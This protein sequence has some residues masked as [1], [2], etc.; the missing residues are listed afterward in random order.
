MFNRLSYCS[1]CGQ[2][3]CHFSFCALSNELVNS[4]LFPPRPSHI[5]PFKLLFSEARGISDGKGQPGSLWGSSSPLAGSCSPASW[6]ACFVLLLLSDRMWSFI[7]QPD[8]SIFITRHRFSAS[9]KAQVPTK[10][11]FGM[12]PKRWSNPS[13]TGRSETLHLFSSYLCQLFSH[14]SGELTGRSQPLRLGSRDCA[15]SCGNPVQLTPP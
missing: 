3:A 15:C 14:S 5:L 8:P 12:G 1:V 9:T 10:H 4:C 2:M 6:C 11:R 13:W 7:T